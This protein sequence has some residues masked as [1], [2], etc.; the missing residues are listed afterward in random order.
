MIVSYEKCLGVMAVIFERA[1]LSPKRARQ[2]AELFAVTE[3]YGVL[4][5]G[6]GLSLKYTEQ[7]LKNTIN[8]EPKVKVL[9]RYPGTAVLDGDQ[10]L[11][12]TV[13]EQAIELVTE[14][15][16]QNGIACVSVT[17]LQHYAAGI[18]YARKPA[19]RGM[20]FTMMAN[21]PKSMAPYGGSRRYYGTN[22][23][24]FSAP[25]G[26]YPMYCLDMATSAVAG[27]KLENAAALGKSVP[28]GQGLDRDGNPC[29]D[30]EEILSHGSLL[31][32]GGAKGS[33]LAGM[34]NIQAGILSGAAYLDD[35]V[36]LCRERSKP[37]NYGCFL[38]AVDIQKFLSLT[39]YCSRAEQWVE[40][41]LKN[42]PAKGFQQVVYPGYLEQ[43]RYE[44]AYREG[45]LLS[46][47]SF[48][49]L[50]EA[51]KRVG[52]DVVDFLE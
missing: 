30:P 41:I 45:I 12:V 16:S 43:Q 48:R 33:G 19:Q 10:G 2:Q 44:Q 38:Q 40:G 32:F 46:E 15:A 13:M 21:S 27:N 50:V 49:N 11:G 3:A 28:E 22:P 23:M 42:P 17:N 34:I 9:H 31:P 7:F 51:G 47:I 52:I 6:V 39:E 1:G 29:T 36:S 24:T 8:T 14:M 18:F 4:S 20:I 5:H 25:M 26:K 35:V 37:A